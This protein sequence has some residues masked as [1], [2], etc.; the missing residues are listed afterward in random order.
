VALET[1]DDS[2]VSTRIGVPAA[3]LETLA[4]EFGEMPMPP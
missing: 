4:Q 3:L 1:F 2:D